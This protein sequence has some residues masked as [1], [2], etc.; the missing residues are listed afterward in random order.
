MTWAFGWLPCPECCFPYRVYDVWVGYQVACLHC[1]NL[2]RPGSVERVARPDGS[3]IDRVT[4][5]WCGATQ[6][7]S[8]LECIG[9]E[10]TERVHYSC[11]D[12]RRPFVVEHAPTVRA[13]DTLVEATPRELAWWRFMRWLRE[14][15]ACAAEATDA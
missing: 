14:R 2:L 12:C 6:D 10:R 1:G 5:P 4:C 3:A 15:D 13:Q 9:A 7:W 11:P 8:A